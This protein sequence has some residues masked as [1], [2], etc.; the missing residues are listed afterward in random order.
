MAWGRMVVE[1]DQQGGRAVGSHIRLE[2]RVLGI[3]LELDEVVTEYTPPSHKMWETV[4]APRLLV[5]GPYRM[6]FTLVPDDLGPTGSTSEQVVLTVFIDYALPDR[7]VSRLLGRLFGSW[8]A[9]WCTSRM[10]DDARA[11]FA[12]STLAAGIH[13]A[14]QPAR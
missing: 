11:A 10:V 5:I 7:G 1:L 9:R 4:G 6:G 14:E 13:R 12:N 3:R 8:Y 2:G